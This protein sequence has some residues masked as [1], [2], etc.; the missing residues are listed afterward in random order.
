MTTPHYI[1]IKS[2][3]ERTAN[4]PYPIPKCKSKKPVGCQYNKWYKEN[5]PQKAPIVEET[6]QKTRQPLRNKI[7]HHKHICMQQHHRPNNAAAVGCAT[8]PSPFRCDNGTCL[9]TLCGSGGAPPFI[10]AH[11]GPC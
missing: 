4:I 3:E 7:V 9:A 10:A 1:G 6:V 8:V 2:G 11:R 5:K